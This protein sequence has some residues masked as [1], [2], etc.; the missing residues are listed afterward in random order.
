[1]VTEMGNC[2]EHVI[3]AIPALGNLAA[4]LHGW[5]LHRQRY[6][7]EYYR[8]IEEILERDTWTLEQ[9]SRYQEENLQRLIKHAAT[10]VPYYREVLR[11]RGL[12]PADIKNV[13]DLQK[14]PIL[15]KSQVRDNPLRFV[16]ERLAVRRL[17]ME[18][19]S[20]TTGIPV[21]L[22]KSNE[23]IQRHFAFFEVRCRRVAGMEYGRLPYV[24]FGI[25]TVA[26]S[27]RTKPPFWCYN[28]VARQL[29][30]SVFHLSPKYLPWYCLEL[31]GRTYHVIM[32]YPSSLYT[33]A[34]YILTKG[35]PTFQMHCAIT[36]GEML[37]PHQRRDICN[38]FGCE[39]FDQY[40]CSENVVFGA[41]C[42]AGAMH[43]S[44]DYGVVEIV[45]DRGNQIPPGQTGELLCTGLLNYAQ[46]LIRYRLGDCGRMS[47]NPCSCG[48]KFP[49][50][51]LIDGRTSEDK[52]ITRDGRRI[53][54]IG[55]VA[56][57]VPHV[58]EFQIVQEDYERY[59][60]NIVPLPGFNDA[61]RAQI[62]HNL[63]ETV[64]RVQ[65]DVKLVAVLERTTSGKV[66]L[67]RSKV[68]TRTKSRL[69]HDENEV[70]I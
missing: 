19:T 21:I 38:A 55:I 14:L 43:L 30:M 44:P 27:W 31:R 52:F 66:L 33:L 5:K 46:V 60:V 34:R 63:T 62:H 68:N 45:D 29:Y 12:S 39:V 41:Q 4:T 54:R 56:E 51:A 10:H 42:P 17:H 18:R 9:I 15:E 20:G 23:S 1:M 48:R 3:W 40:G 2:G 59:T 67:V 65:I 35:E 64:G 61:D 47:T 37:L 50:L 32:G 26:P 13:S 49:V 16:D 36:S 28:Y 11:D 25:Q 22:Y 69:E 6:G 70:A 58:A 57:D 8:C 53:S 24:M 7:N